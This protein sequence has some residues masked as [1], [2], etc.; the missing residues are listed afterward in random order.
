MLCALGW[1][2]AVQG[3]GGGAAPGQMKPT[4]ANAAEP[5]AEA[6]VTAA[7]GIPTSHHVVLVMEE[8]QSYSSVVHDAGRW[9][10]LNR[11]ISRGAL[12]TKYFANAH[13]SIGNYFMLTTGQVLTNNDDSTRVWNVDNLARRMLEYGTQFR[14]Y[15]EGI[16]RGD[17]GD[18]AG[19]YLVRHDPFAMLSDIADNH[20]V[21]E[22]KMWPFTQFAADVRDG[23]LQGFSYIVPDVYHDAHSASPEE[24]DAWLEKYVVEPLSVR[25]AF[26][27]GGDGILIVDF[28]EA[29]DSDTRYGGGQVAAVFWG[30]Q[31]KAGY[32]QKSSTVYQ[33]QSMLR[34]VMEALHLPNPP[35][36]AAGAPAMG[37]FFR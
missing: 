18:N 11:L 32:A 14:I 12:A 2:A 10:N 1:C 26:E 25:P 23:G 19:A 20:A 24:A 36:K 37:E 16:W 9:P 21:A 35:G 28:D 30:P 7:A 27:P 6:S 4:A 15:A 31:V 33:H 5:A 3:C 17:T 34:T 8:N 13:P 22:A 29:A